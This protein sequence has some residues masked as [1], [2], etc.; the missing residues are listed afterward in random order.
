MYNA[1]KIYY[2]ENASENNYKIVITMRTKKNALNF[3]RTFVRYKIE[4]ANH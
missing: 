3:Y 4:N 1:F 2:F